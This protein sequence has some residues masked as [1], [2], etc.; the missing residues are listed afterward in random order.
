MPAD[1][2]VT[3]SDA[4]RSQGGLLEA[5]YADLAWLRVS[6]DEGYAGTCREPRRDARAAHRL[7]SE[8]AHVR[9][10]PPL[11]AARVRGRLLRFAQVA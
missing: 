1:R 6:W 5:L 7:S 8:Q 9:L 10:A 11:P 4:Q 2:V 3:R